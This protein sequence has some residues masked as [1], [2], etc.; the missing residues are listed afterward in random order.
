MRALWM[1][2][3]L[4]QPVR[5]HLGLPANPGPQAWVDRLAEELSRRGKVHV[6]IAAPAPQAFAPFEAGD[7]RYHGLPAPPERGRVGRILQGWRHRPASPE[8]LAAAGV[9]I[10]RERP[11]LVHLQGTESVL[12]PAAVAGPAPCLVSLQGLMQAC[13]PLYFAGRTPAEL[14]LLVLSEDFVKGRGVAQDYV[15]YRQLARR[16]VEVM[17]AARWFVGRTDWDRA[18]LAAT[19]SAAA[20]FHC[21]EIVREEFWGADWTAAAASR[22]K[23]PRLYSTSSRMP[24]KGAETLLRAVALLLPAYPGLRLRVAGVP[25]GEE[26]DR[27]YRR[28]ARRLGVDGA[29]DWL[30]RLDA[31][32][33]AAELEAADVFVYPSHIDNSPNAIVEAMLA[34]T[35]VVA[36]YTGGIPSLLRGGE[37]GLLAP[38]GD[39]PAF[40]AAVRRL[41][42]DPR[43][44][45]RLGAAARARARERND[46]AR[47]TARMTEIYTAVVAAANERP[48]A[49]VES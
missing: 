18:V 45:G 6:E 12:G 19:N 36:S 41:L 24:F 2:D 48:P 44:A 9:L 34:G 37:E 27:L 35:P 4:P 43:L 28:A 40:A 22:T 7:V 13:A 46:P 33:I 15:R 3:V 5:E 20:Y 8:M 26:M 47:V 29:V 32:A 17:R 1:T 39:A 42:D 38:R 10:A 21:E 14:A 49:E 31:A 11:D 16:E 25:A 23:G 30:G